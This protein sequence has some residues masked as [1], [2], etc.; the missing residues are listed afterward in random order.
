MMAAQAWLNLL[1]LDEE[2]AAGKWSEGAALT[3]VE[4]RRERDNLVPGP[5]WRM[6]TLLALKNTAEGVRQ[7]RSCSNI[8]MA[9]K[10]QGVCSY[11]S[12][13]I[14]WASAQPWVR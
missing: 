1:L 2:K 4:N 11:L 8:D 9:E 3:R 12:S 7:A 6:L 14:S 10:L 13:E 5:V